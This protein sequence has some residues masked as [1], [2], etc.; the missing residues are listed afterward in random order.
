MAETYGCFN[1]VDDI[2]YSDLYDVQA[3]GVH[4][5]DSAVRQDVFGFYIKRAESALEEIAFIFKMRQVIANKK[6]G[7]G[8]AIISGDKLY[9]YSADDLV[10]P[11]SN[12]PTSYFCGWA[13]K[14]AGANDTTVLMEF[15][16]TRYNENI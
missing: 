7:T 8:E 3:T 11:V 5:G 13:R 9:Y 4:K 16:G 15:D 10:S 12:Y 1:P 14:S 6:T 2:I